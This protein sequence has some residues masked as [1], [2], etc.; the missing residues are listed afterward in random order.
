MGNGDVSLL[1]IDIRSSIFTHCAELD[2]MAFWCKF[3]DGIQNIDRSNNV[4]ALRIDSSRPVQHRV[5]CGP[6]FSKVNHCKST[7][8]INATVE[9]SPTFSKSF[10][11]PQKLPAVG[12]NSINE[13]DKNS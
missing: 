4:I 13:L 12:S 10:R 5:G 3:L 2:Q 8:N 1:N 11:K 6:L 9:K 7:A